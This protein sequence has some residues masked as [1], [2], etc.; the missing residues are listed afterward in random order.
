MKIEN[1]IDYG[2]IND[3]TQS[4]ERSLYKAYNN[5][6]A[7]LNLVDADKKTQK[8]NEVLYYAAPKY[9]GKTIKVLND[10]SITILNNAYYQKDNNYDVC[11][12]INHL[13]K[14]ML[15]TGN[16]TKEAELELIE[17]ND[18]SNIVYYKTSFFGYD[19]SNSKELLNAIKNDRLYV[20]INEIA[21]IN[22]FGY[23]T[24]SK[25]TCDRIINSSSKHFS[26]LTAEYKNGKFQQICGDITFSIYIREHKI[27]Y[28]LKGKNNTQRLYDTSYYKN[29]KNY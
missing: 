26:Y 1:L 24:L 25:A 5:K 23:Q 27:K 15:F 29:L 4:A 14:R 9:S 10:L 22:M 13:G 21:N 17:N 19:G 2:T 11:L 12:T 16:I 7:E 20:V 18:L 6:K 8:E 28:S 3:P